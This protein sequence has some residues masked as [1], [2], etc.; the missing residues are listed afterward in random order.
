VFDRK[1]IGLQKQTTGNEGGRTQ[2]EDD[3]MRKNCVYLRGQVED[4]GN[5]LER[6]VAIY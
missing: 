1:F 6:E 2:K 3:S 5:H 4:K